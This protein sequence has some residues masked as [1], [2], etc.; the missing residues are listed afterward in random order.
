MLSGWLC[1]QAA[2]IRTA[3]SD[4]AQ[5]PVNALLAHPHQRSAAYFHN[6]GNAHFLADQLPEAILAYQHGLRLD[7]NDGGLRENLEY[8]RARVQAP[9]GERGRPEADNWPDWLYRPSA[10]QVLAATFLIY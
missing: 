5:Q 8:A 7:P 10:F 1:S 6:L 4:N 3:S 9:F 2:D